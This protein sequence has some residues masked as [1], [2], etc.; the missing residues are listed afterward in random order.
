MPPT[1]FFSKTQYVYPKP[2]SETNIAECG[3]PVTHSFLFDILRENRKSRLHS[4]GGTYSILAF[5]IDDDQEPVS[6]TI[7]FLVHVG[8]LPNE[9]MKI[10]ARENTR[11]MLELITKRQLESQRIAEIYASK[12][13]HSHL[14]N[15]S[16][17]FLDATFL[18]ILESGDLQRIRE[19]VTR[20]SDKSPLFS[21]QLFDPEVLRLHSQF[22]HHSV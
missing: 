15:F 11:S 4:Q 16:K 2:L 1:P 22:H 6:N 19:A 5:L 18:D 9:K 12:R 8:Q 13:A 20:E 14:Y 3:H 7:E 21:F 10:D 17:S